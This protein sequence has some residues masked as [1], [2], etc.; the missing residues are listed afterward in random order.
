MTAIPLR[1][2]RIDFVLIA[3]YIINLFFITY[4]VDLEQLVIADPSHFTYPSW[5][6]AFFVDMVHDYGRHYDP[7]LMARPPWWRATIWID[8]LLFGP[9]YVAALYAFIKGKN[10]IRTPALLW[11]AVMMTN[12]T[13]ILFE[14][15]LGPYATPAW[16]RV[17]A[18]NLPWLLM[19]VLTIWRMTRSFRPFSHE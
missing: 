15:R 7:V 8:A 3:F 2:R 5:P 6:P 16:P 13:I 11:S 19:P 4:I 10:W 9:Y 18:L 12:V 14:E 17:L 1:E